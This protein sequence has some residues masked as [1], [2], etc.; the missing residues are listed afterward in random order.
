MMSPDIKRELEAK[1]S[2]YPLAAV[3]I[4][5]LAGAVVALGRRS[6]DA[7]TT[8]RTVSSVLIGGISA[9]AMGVVKDALLGQLSGAAKSW[10]DP[11]GA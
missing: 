4:A 9:L 5:L 11:E 7:A 2:A 6:R 10:L 8:K 1:I 3:A